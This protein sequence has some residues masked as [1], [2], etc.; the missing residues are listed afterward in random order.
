MADLNLVLVP[1]SVDP[2]TPFPPSWRTMIREM[3]EALTIAG[4]P[5]LSLANYGPDEPDAGNVDKPWIRTDAD[6]RPMGTWIFYDGSWVLDYALEI[7][8]VRAFS[9]AVAD[10]VA[11]FVLADGT[12]SSTHDCTTAMTPTGVQTTYVL[13][14]AEWVGYP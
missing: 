10:L 5:S 13:G 7:G 6:G 1:S 3:S 12:G 9:G 8:D 2:S 11:G 4:G 14:F